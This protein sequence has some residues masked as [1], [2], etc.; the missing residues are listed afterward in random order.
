MPVI[1]RPIEYI[2]V[3]PVCTVYWSADDWKMVTHTTIEPLEI[4]F[5]GRRWVAVG[6]NDKGEL[7]YMQR[8]TFA[9]KEGA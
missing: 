9:T 8:D 7:I 4:E 3:P 6:R 1:P 5:F 2:N